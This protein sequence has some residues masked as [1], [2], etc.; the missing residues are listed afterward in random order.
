M[1]AN[2]KDNLENRRFIR[3]KDIPTL[4]GITQMTALRW[5]KSGKLPEPI[6]L[7]TRV[8]GWNREILDSIFFGQ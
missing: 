3:L 6:R 8:V 1:T 2:Q 7:S 5:I 4:Y